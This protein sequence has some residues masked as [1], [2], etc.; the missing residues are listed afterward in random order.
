M[1]SRLIAFSLPGYFT[2]QIP[3]SKDMLEELGVGFR[4][5][6]LGFRGFRGFRVYGLGARALGY[7]GIP[8]EH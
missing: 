8:E 6:G 2:D 5:Y 7:T 4:V 1:N 3:G